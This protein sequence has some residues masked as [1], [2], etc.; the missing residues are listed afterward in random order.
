MTV[1]EKILESN[2]KVRFHDCDPFNHLH[3][4]RYIDYIMAARSEQLEA[5]YQFDVY[6]LAREQGVSWVAAQ[7]QVSYLQPA[8]LMEEV[9]IQ[10]RLFS[11]TEKSLLAEGI[12][13]NRNKTAAKA[14]LWIK[15]VHC[16]IKTG[17]SH[18]HSD[19]L[20]EFFGRIAYPL[21]AGAGFGE[22]AKSL[23]LHTNPS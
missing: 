22:R 4:S 13:W 10:T 5:H 7:A 21:P 16:N 1:F 23:K 6:K 20:L 15:L 18:V 3:N 8:L 12:M 17:K 9:T 14:L 11:Y 19:A 2:T